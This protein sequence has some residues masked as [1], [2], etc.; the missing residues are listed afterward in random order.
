MLWIAWDHDQRVRGTRLFR[1]I[2]VTLLGQ[3]GASQSEAAAYDLAGRLA[4][5]P[6][7]MVR[8]GIEETIRR[9][10]WATEHFLRW[11]WSRQG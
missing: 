6:D 8:L 9:Q 2:A 10:T 5:P 4:A 11:W 3:R 7:L 1:A